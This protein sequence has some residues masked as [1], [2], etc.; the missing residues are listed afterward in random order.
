VKLSVVTSQTVLMYTAKR[1]V[2]MK[3]DRFLVTGL[4]RLSCMEPKYVFPIC[5]KKLI[6]FLFTPQQMGRHGRINEFNLS[7]TK[8]NLLI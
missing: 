4:P 5:L 6:V 8:R 1:C 2:N 3:L 7:K